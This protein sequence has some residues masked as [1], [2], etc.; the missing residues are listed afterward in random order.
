[1]A[2]RK[3]ETYSTA[4]LPEARTS[5]ELAQYSIDD[6]KREL[7]VREQQEKARLRNLHRERS[8]A[9][10]EGLN[11]QIIDALVPQHGRTSCDDTNLANG[12]NSSD[13]VLPRCNRCALLQALHGKSWPEEFSLHAVIE[14]NPDV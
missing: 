9:L 8:I 1:M 10:A 12:W 2:R 3:S 14:R 4:P 7:L 13:E 6:L 11:I 5:Q